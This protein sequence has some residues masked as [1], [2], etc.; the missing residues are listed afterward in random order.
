[1]TTHISDSVGTTTRWPL[2]RILFAMAGT[3]T[4]VSALLAALVSPWFLLLTA[5][6][7]I[8]QW[9]YVTIQACPASVVL[10][11]IGIEP[12]CHW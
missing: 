3:M 4:L 2:E 8:N 5:F 12:Q 6:V 1:M 7:G 11:R 10:R 9:M